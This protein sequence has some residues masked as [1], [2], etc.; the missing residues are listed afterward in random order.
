[1]NLF[2]FGKDFVCV[3][4]VFVFVLAVPPTWVVEPSS[5]SVALGGSLALPCLARG[6]PDPVTTWRRQTG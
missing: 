4:K 3:V 2:L 6:F 5:A 1:M